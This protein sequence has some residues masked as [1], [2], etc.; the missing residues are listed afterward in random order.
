ML[1]PLFQPTSGVLD[2][3]YGPDEH[4]D[5]GE[6][7]PRFTWMPA[8]LEES[9]YELQISSKTEFESEDTLTYSRIPYNLFTPDKPLAPGSYYWRYSLIGE[10]DIRS[11]WSKVRAFV[12]EDELPLTPLP[13]RT[14]RYSAASANHPRLWLQAEQLPFTGKLS[15]K[16]RFQL[17]GKTS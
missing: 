6:N 10:K 16:T 7:P 14:E 5:V 9:M 12:V 13:S 17:A 3:S 15:A 1:E 2:L 8:C 11:E 4:I